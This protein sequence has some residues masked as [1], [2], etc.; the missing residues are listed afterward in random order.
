MNIAASFAHVLQGGPVELDEFEK[1]ISRPLLMLDSSMDE[2]MQTDIED[3]IAD[4]LMRRSCNPIHIHLRLKQGFNPDATLTHRELHDMATLMFSD[5]ANQARELA[6]FYTRIANLRARIMQEQATQSQSHPDQTMCPINGRLQRAYAQQTE[7]MHTKQRENRAH[8]E[9][10]MRT[11]VLN[12]DH[13]DRC[14]HPKLTNLELDALELQVQDILEC[15]CATHELRRIKIVEAAIE[16]QTCDALIAEL[17]ALDTQLN[18]S[19]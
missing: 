2:K 6:R 19:H 15:G 14:I 16:E 4:A 11:L 8:F 7:N 17:N 10:I 1:E 9:R 3:I 5:K 12:P 18:H 13:E